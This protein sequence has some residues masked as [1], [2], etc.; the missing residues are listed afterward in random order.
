[1]KTPSLT[2]AITGA[3]G[4]IYA[5]L[6]M[7]ALKTHHMLI[8]PVYVLQS[9]NA[10][11]VWNIEQPQQDLK[12]YPFTYVK[13]N[14]FFSPVA[15][16]SA[17]PDTMVICPCSMGTLGRIAAGLSN[18][19]IGR[20]ADVC[21]KERKKLILVLRETPYNT[22]HIENMRR[23]AQAGAILIPATPSFYSNPQTIEDL[24][25]TV[26]HRILDHINI[27]HNGYRWGQN[28]S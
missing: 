26:V 25:F 8:N 16:G 20:A 21:L 17:A 15:S 10:A 28:K 5:R 1:M 4:S 12:A 9:P 14:D 2:L 22:I 7:D 13:N 3:S 24:C 23:V 11:T 18:D 6:L 27:P 19:L